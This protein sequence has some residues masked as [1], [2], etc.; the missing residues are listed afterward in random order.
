M[1]FSKDIDKQRA[2]KLMPPL[3]RVNAVIDTDTFN[4]VD[5]QLA[6]AYALLSPDRIN[7][8]AVYSAPFSSTFFQRLLGTE[9]LDIPMISDLESGQKMSFQEIKHIFHLLGKSSEGK[10]FMGSKK[11]L[12]SANEPVDSDAARDLVT[13]A[14]NSEDLLY[15]IC[16]GAITNVASA[17]IMEPRIIDKISII[18]LA[19]QPLHWPHAVEFNLCQDIIASQVVLNSTVPV[20]LVPCM[21]V[22]SS[23]TTTE[24][25]LNEYINGRNEISTFLSER[26]I[27]EL[28]PKAAD[29]WLSL[30]RQTYLKGLDDYSDEINERFPTSDSSPSRIVW[31]ISTIGYII[32]PKWCPSS[33]VPTPWLTDDMKWKHDSSRHKMRVV[34]YVYRDTIFGDMFAKLAKAN[35]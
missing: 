7:V 20:T 24:A 23:L 8:E 18:W 35:V 22:A 4:E 32:D 21:A 5:D 19:G 31:D 12:A 6:L 15:V 29:G 28:D 11:Y 2:L 14:M 10:V 33:L 26:V 13:R 16:I 34:N 1:E 3:E 25:E 9:S 27:K 17:I 30:F